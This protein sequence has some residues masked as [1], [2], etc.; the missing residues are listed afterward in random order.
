M[1][2]P[3][4]Y[5]TAMC[6][7]L[8][9]SGMVSPLCLLQAPP[10]PLVPCLG[11]LKVCLCISAQSLASATL[12]IK[13]KWGQGFLSVLQPMCRFSCNFGVPDQHNTS[14]IRPNSQHLIPE[15]IVKLNTVE[16]VLHKTTLSLP[17]LEASPPGSLACH[18][19]WWPL[20]PTGLPFSPCG[21]L[22]LI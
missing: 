6:S 20:P 3:S 19:I 21:F 18:L 16:L 7:V 4:S 5:M 10:P 2:S 9:L 14:S 12:P 13:T 1:H 11:I 22:Y 8:Y 17:S 15:P